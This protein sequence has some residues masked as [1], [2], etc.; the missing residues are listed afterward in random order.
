MIPMPYIPTDCEGGNPVSAPK[1]GGNMPLEDSCGCPPKLVDI[2]S[3]PQL[4]VV[5]Q[6]CDARQ[7]LM[8][9]ETKY[10]LSS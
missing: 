6:P 5:V 10:I 9:K 8:N 1:V 3:S 2:H 7:F 4:K